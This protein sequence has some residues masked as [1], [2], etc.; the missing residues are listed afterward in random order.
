[1]K[2]EVLVPIDKAGRLV[3]PKEVREE[4]AIHP[5]DVLKVSIQGNEVTLRPNKEPSG[6]VRKGH[7]LVFSSGGSDLLENETVNS[8]LSAHRE[9][10]TNDISKGLTRKKH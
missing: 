3:L 9:S 4:L 6:F 10:A 2:D 5:G 7:V 8:L 1:M